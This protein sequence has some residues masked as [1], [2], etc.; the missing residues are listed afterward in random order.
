MCRHVR[1]I[2]VFF[3][4]GSKALLVVQEELC[5]MT[6]SASL[7]QQ[8]RALSAGLRTGRISASQF[9]VQPARH[10][11]TAFLESIQEHVDTLKQECK[12][13]WVELKKQGKQLSG[14]GPHTNDSDN[15]GAKQEDDLD[16]MEEG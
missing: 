4:H 10:G 8:V 13:E 5:S 9:G 12:A 2:L 11:I 15:A 6:R 1:K 7:W 16:K 3:V 14:D